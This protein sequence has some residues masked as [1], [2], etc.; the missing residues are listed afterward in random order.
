MRRIKTYFL[1]AIAFIVSGCKDCGCDLQDTTLPSETVTTNSS[2]YVYADGCAKPNGEVD[3]SG[4]PTGSCDASGQYV[5]RGRW[6]KAPNISVSQGSQVNINTEGSI[7]YCSTGYDNQN[8]ATT[9]VVKPSES[10][11]NVFSDGSQMPVVEGQVILIN[12]V[13]DVTNSSALYVG[14][15]ISGENSTT[16]C[17]TLSNPYNSFTAG[18]CQGYNL[19]GLTVY[20][21][22]TEIVNLDST[23][24]A[25]SPYY[26]YAESRK[27]Y[28][29]SFI[30]PNIRSSF[31]SEINAKYNIPLNNIGNGIYSFM[32]PSGI[33]GKLG[34]AIARGYKKKIT[35]HVFGIPVSTV[36][37][38]GVGKYTFQIMSTSPA[39]Y[40]EQAIAGSHP[41]NRGALE[42]L[43]M[44]TNP[45][46]VDSAIASFNSLNGGNEIS[47]YYQEL[48]KYISS[49]TGI[50][51]NSNSSILS[52]LVI[53]SAPSLS[54][55]IITKSSYDLDTS[56]IS[57]GSIW[58]RVRDDYYSDN[59]GQYNVSIIFRKYLFY[60]TK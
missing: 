26:P 48:N 32:V 41:G 58:L 16:N 33:N 19:L 6:V 53:N 22:N 1:I 42:L 38:T 47:V 35:Y 50:T 51:I 37:I 4:F 15:N 2:L 5:N 39:C 36:H 28:L 20:V 13:P 29:F 8:P 25:N 9:F 60:I 46:D 45:N 11:A 7:Y 10:V 56:N 17:S 44:S 27:P 54:P 12:T 43:V 49:F 55:F 24:T 18:D 14:V 30:D 59:V 57:N 31:F 23:Y 21:D 40:V 52:D 34:F 3:S